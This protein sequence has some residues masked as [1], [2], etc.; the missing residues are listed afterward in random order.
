MRKKREI[1]DQEDA[2]DDSGKKNEEEEKMDVRYI[3]KNLWYFF[4]LNLVQDINGR[5]LMQ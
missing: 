4:A 3:K 1:K 5:L 2:E